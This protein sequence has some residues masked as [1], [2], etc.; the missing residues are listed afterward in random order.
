MWSNLKKR[1]TPLGGN[2]QLSIKSGVSNEKDNIGAYATDEEAY[3]V[4]DDLFGPIVRDLHPDYDMKYSFKDEFDLSKIK[5]KLKQIESYSAKIDKISISARRNFREIP[6]APLV[7][8]E[9]KVNVE[10]RASEILGDLFG[11]Y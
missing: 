7:N 1:A 2:I 3:K 5:D 4:F 10:K 11:E 6:F 8:K 9:T